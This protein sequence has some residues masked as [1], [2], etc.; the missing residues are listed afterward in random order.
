VE[1]RRLNRRQRD[2]PPWFLST[3]EDEDGSCPRLEQEGVAILRRILRRR[4]P[5]RSQPVQLLIYH[6]WKERRYQVRQ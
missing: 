1:V 4:G 2:L 6:F 5:G 3:A